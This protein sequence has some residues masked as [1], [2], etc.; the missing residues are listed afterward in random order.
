MISIRINGQNAA[1][2][3]EF[4]FEFTRENNLFDSAEG[5]S[6][7]MEFILSDC[8]QNQKI[9][10][11]I[12]LPYIHKPTDLLPAEI[13]GSGINLRGALAIMEVTDYSVK[14][15]FLEGVD[16]D[17]SQSKLEETFINEL[18]LGEFS[19][20]NPDDVNPD[21]RKLS[22]VAAWCLPWTS[23]QF[24]VVNN[25]T[26]I[27]DSRLV[28]D[29]KTTRLSW[30]P[31]LDS[32]IVNILNK[33]GYSFNQVE[34]NNMLL[35]K[36]LSGALICNTLP[37]SW[38]IADVAAILPHWSVI[39][40]FDKFAAW[41]GLSVSWNHIDKSINF[42]DKAEIVKEAGEYYVEKVLSEYSAKVSRDEEDAGYLPMK[43]VKYK[44]SEEDIWKY[45]CCPEFL[46]QQL[47]KAPQNIRRF[48]TWEEALP[49]IKNFTPF[50][51]FLSNRNRFAGSIIYIKDVDTYF[52]MRANYTTPD[53]I[54]V[55]SSSKYMEFAQMTP[56]NIFGPPVDNY[57]EDANYEELE[58]VPVIVDWTDQG[59][60]MIL[61]V[62]SLDDGSTLEGSEFDRSGKT[63]VIF[64][65]GTSL[66]ATDSLKI[67]Q[68]RLGQK[69]E[70]DDNSV[71]QYF[72][73]IY[74]GFA[75]SAQMD[76]WTYGKYTN[77]VAPAAD[78]HV[79][80]TQLWPQYKGAMR[81]GNI[82]LGLENVKNIDPKVVYE[83]SFIA[84]SLPDIN[85]VFVVNAT[86]FV[87]SKLSCSINKTGMSKI[88]NGE[89]YRLLD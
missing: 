29:E 81:L 38:G 34:F 7:E 62:G 78:I 54:S 49:E 10:G 48:E 75:P 15:Q 40:F 55:D 25:K 72:D 45:W 61:P 82:G 87:C 67:C 63:G 52:L 33:I 36:N 2:S 76:Y 64:P 16:V 18:D 14:C 1:I 31:R 50:N 30:Q 73:R 21:E 70:A 22:G 84:D 77:Q 9:F 26:D 88:I 37:P 5:Y 4:S 27:K 51:K 85:A 60:M 53:G 28:W 71:D 43:R 42:K 39:E 79:W 32:V 41:C 59:Q 80:L 65:D 46:K 68:N 57:D 86:R 3:D 23:R 11:F 74:I 17:E 89:F 24:D 56:L 12:R 83:F 58:F 20:L 19:H 44:D 66:W 8:P 47:E 35:R 6:F 13:Q 69:L